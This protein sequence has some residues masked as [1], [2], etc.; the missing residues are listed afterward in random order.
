VLTGLLAALILVVNLDYSKVI[1]AIVPVSVIWANLAYLLVTA[2][3]LVRRL[4]GWPARGG[5]SAREVFTLGRWGLPINAGAVLFGVFV[6]V[7]MSWPRPDAETTW[8]DKAALIFTAAMLIPGVLYYALVQRR[9]TQV[10]P[11][12]RAT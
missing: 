3:L 12:H 6:I 10:L 4:R 9:R 7:N 2:S 5:S 11:E 1:D 8:E